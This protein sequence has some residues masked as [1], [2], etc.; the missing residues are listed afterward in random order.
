[1]KVLAVL[2]TVQQGCHVNRG[3]FGNTSLFCSETFPLSWDGQ[4]SE[5]QRVSRVQR[6]GGEV[7]ESSGHHD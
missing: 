1:M 2:K 4:R 6:D 7:S 5:V 3:Q